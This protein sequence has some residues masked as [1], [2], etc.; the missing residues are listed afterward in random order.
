MA[1]TL[2]SIYLNTSLGSTELDDG[3]HTLLTTNST[4]RYVI[5][6]MHVNGT[7]GLTNTYLELNGFNVGSISSNATGSLIIPPNSTLKIKTTDYP[8][9]FTRERLTFLDS[10]DY[11]VYRETYSNPLMGSNLGTPITMVSVYQPTRYYQLTRMYYKVISG[12]PYLHYTTSDNNSVQ[13]L[14]YATTTAHGSIRNDNYRPFGV[15]E[16]PTLGYIGI[17]F[18]GNNLYYTDLDAN[19]TGSSWQ[20][21]SNW[22]GTKNNGSYDPTTSSYPRGFVQFGYFWYRRSNSYTAINA[23]NLTNGTQHQFNM[24]G[25]APTSSNHF[26]VTHRKSDDKFLFWKQTGGGA[27]EVAI[28][29]ETKTA[30]DATNQSGNNDVSTSGPTSGAHNS[31]NLTNNFKNANM[32]SNVAGFDENGNLIYQDTNNLLVTLGIDN[33]VISTTTSNSYDINGTIRTPLSTGNFHRLEKTT[34]TASEATT[35]GLTGSSF[36]IQLLGIKS[37]T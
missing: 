2:E 35:A 24:G 3:E 23:V 5:K 26:T 8:F 32:S 37:E 15:Y 22:G 1:D 25:G 10:Q 12:T 4:T 33:T 18:E 7:S 30:L 21:P 17:Y 6:D 13:H 9:V 27:I 19:P 14:R 16:H 20:N 31:L 36:G 29:D 28:S 34:M 11:L